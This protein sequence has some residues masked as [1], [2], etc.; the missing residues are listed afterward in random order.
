MLVVDDELASRRIIGAHLARE[1]YHV[2]YASSGPEALETARRE[3]PD[4]ITLD[5]MMPQV[6]GWSVL[7]AL[8]ADHD[9][10][11]IPVVLVSLAADR[12][13]GLALGA[14]A[15]L[16]KPVDRAELAA[17]IRATSAA[18]SAG[19][20]LVVEDDPV[21]RSLVERTIE[22]VGLRAAIA[23]N[24]REALDWLKLNPV[25]AL[26]LLDLLMP[27]MDGFEFLR[28]LRGQ[29]DWAKIPVVVLT[30]K[31][32]SEAERAMLAES[33]RQV[34]TKGSTSQLGLSQVLREVIL[35]KSPAAPGGLP[36]G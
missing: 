18:L 25:P 6:D 3:R 26:I 24:G 36:E 10:E 31:S 15:V 33:T 20:V 17:A 34:V 28:H 4:A 11:A 9:L 12:R 30:A 16:T 2:I 27:V 32:L 29:P 7:Q 8:K 1:R 14:A 23:G 19:P 35:A 5:I 22:R 21:V 13:L